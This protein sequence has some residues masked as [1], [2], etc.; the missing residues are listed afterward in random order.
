MLLN[1]CPLSKVKDPFAI[2]PVNVQKARD[3]DPFFVQSA[4]EKEPV[5]TK[6]PPG[7]VLLVTMRLPPEPKVALVV[8]LPVASV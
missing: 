6:P 2:V 1:T 3:P 8:S 5:N 7:P 4:L